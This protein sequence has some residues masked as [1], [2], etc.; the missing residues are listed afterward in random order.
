MNSTIA[1][2]VALFVALVVSCGIYDNDYF[3]VPYREG[4][5]WGLCDTLGKVEVQPEYDN[6]I[7]MIVDKNSKQSFYFVK[8]NKTTIVVDHNNIRHLQQYDS[9]DPISYRI[10]KDGKIGLFR[11][12]F[13]SNYHKTTGQFEIL[14]DAIYNSIDPIDAKRYMLKANGKV[15][16][17]FVEYDKASILLP[18]E[19]DK[20]DYEKPV[21][22]GYKDGVVVT[23]YRD[24][25]Y[26]SSG[27][28]LDSGTAG[29][30]EQ[31]ENKKKQ[32]QKDEQERKK[33]MENLTRDAS[34][35]EL[36]KIRPFEITPLNK[37]VKFREN[38]Q[39]GYAHFSYSLSGPTK[40]LIR[41]EVMP[42]IYDSISECGLFNFILK[43]DG[44]FGFSLMKR[45]LVEPI[46]D[47]IKF[48]N[49]NIN[50]LLVK[51][52][53]KYA[54]FKLGDDKFLSDFIYDDYSL[55]PNTVYQ[56]RLVLRKGKKKVIWDMDKPSEEYD[57][58]TPL[59]AGN[60]AGNTSYINALKCRNGNRHGIWSDGRVSVPIA[61]DDL[62]V[63]NEGLLI[64]VKNGKRGTYEKRGLINIPPMYKS[65]ELFENF[66]FGDDIYPLYQV[67]NVEGVLFY[68][69]RKGNEFYKP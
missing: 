15:G 11:Y 42:A 2:K 8:K 60:G 68:T 21:Y 9:V 36:K 22:K 43:K 24:P 6:F 28:A 14:A 52:G 66:A 59:I 23:E 55:I 19:Y 51:K 1:L 37:Y 40:K 13:G 33:I 57:D 63:S 45:V 46:Y 65:V 62:Y 20:I 67:V 5:K 39:Q 47:D 16:L 10:Y 58:I 29:M 4:D 53:G 69:D 61:Y 30:R 35:E 18:P 27:I 41:N 56:Y 7:K 3:L 48:F 31:E 38:G 12:K 26:A 34:P 54:V 32:D 44:K 50:G 17:L 64:T 49:T 25:I